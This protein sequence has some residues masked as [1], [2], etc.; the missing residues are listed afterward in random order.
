MASLE[1]LLYDIGEANSSLGEAEDPCSPGP[2]RKN[3]HEAREQVEKRMGTIPLYCRYH[4]LPS[5]ISDDYE[6]T[7]SVLGAGLNGE[8]RLAYSKHRPKVKYAVK[9]FPLKDLTRAEMR[10]LKSEMLVALCMD[11]PNVARL[12][13]AYE[14]Q[15]NLSLVTE[16]MLGGDLYD[17]FDGCK[18][19]WTISQSCDALWQILLALNYIHSHGIAHRDIKHGNIL[20]DREDSGHLVLIDFGFSRALETSESWSPAARNMSADSPRSFRR[21]ESMHTP[22]GTQAFMAPEVRALRGYT[23][24]CDLWSVGI[25]AYQ[26]LT[27]RMPAAKSPLRHSFHLRGTAR[28]TDPPGE[29]VGCD[30]S[31]MSMSNTA[32][33]E[34]SVQSICSQEIL[35]DGVDNW[36]QLPASAKDFVSGLLQSNPEQRLTAKAAL[37][38]PFLTETLSHRVVSVTPSVVESLSHFCGMPRIRRCCLLMI[39]W[40]LSA[41]EQALVRDQFVEINVSHTGT[42]TKQ[43]FTN[44][45]QGVRAGSSVNSNAEDGVNS[46]RSCAS[47][48]FEELDVC[49][50]REIHFSTFLAAMMPVFIGWHD[51]ILKAT[52]RRFEPGEPGH[53]HIESMARVFGETPE[54]GQNASFDAVFDEYGGT[55]DGLVSFDTFASYVADKKESQKQVKTPHPVDTG[56]AVS[57]SKV[58][59]VLM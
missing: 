28:G 42:I 44:L 53:V 15:S 11:H 39:A 27:G 30:A 37:R 41:D 6:M 8:V 3:L 26:L 18:D 46:L 54:P 40:S 35:L 14:S 19:T 5:K 45:L 29:A 52:F 4:S 17:R 20:F 48:V 24:Q 50:D 21:R 55:Q 2:V 34:L 31:T 36:K 25:I 57:R 38:H 58:C 33:E 49:H 9:K 16:C 1:S 43:E 23:T 59:C 22:C 13:D 56:R 51:D 12:V 32:S 10:L 7:S 47:D